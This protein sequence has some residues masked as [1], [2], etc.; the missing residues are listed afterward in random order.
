[1]C[2]YNNTGLF[3]SMLEHVQ[4]IQKHVFACFVMT[5]CFGGDGDTSVQS[6]I[7]ELEVWTQHLGIDVVIYA[8]TNS[9]AVLQHCFPADCDECNH[10]EQV[11]YVL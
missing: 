4:T 9:V 6:G 7:P 11:I 5:T 1:M 8:N 3:Y 2:K 10:N